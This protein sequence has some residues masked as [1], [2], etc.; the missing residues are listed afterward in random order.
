MGKN[1]D[2]YFHYSVDTIAHY[3]IVT[4]IAGSFVNFP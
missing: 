3:V 1:R 4:V 2:Y